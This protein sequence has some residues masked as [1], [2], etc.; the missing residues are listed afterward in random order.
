MGITR[1]V[2]RAGAALL[3]AAVV[4]GALAGCNEIVPLD[5]TLR[6]AFVTADPDDDFGITVDGVVTRVTAPASNTSANTRL[7]FWRT[8]APVTA[9]QRS[10]VSWA[11][12][13]TTTSHHLQQGVALRI[14]AE[15]GRTRAVAVTKNMW[16]S[17][18]WTYDVHV[19]DSAADQP[20]VRIGRVDVLDVVVR[21]GVLAPAP[22]HLC[23][24]VVGG[25]VTVKVWPGDVAE[26]PWGDGVHG[27][28]VALP[29]GW[30]A[31]GVAGWYAGHVG[32]G[33]VLDVVDPRIVPLSAVPAAPADL[34][35]S[36]LGKRHGEPAPRE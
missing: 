25:T 23:A 7:V 12:E 3:A 30:D 31:P 29:P 24:Q 13:D 5:P 26:P 9:D 36:L 10:C 16:S 14:R 19:M 27:G 4:T 21:S 28:S 8:T 6:A 34:V 15:T 35:G 33:Q 1:G 20:F 18:F 22:W 11:E 2:R 17:G 32:P